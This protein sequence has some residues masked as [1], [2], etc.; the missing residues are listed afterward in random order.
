MDV[1][2]K[3]AQVKQ[4]FAAVDNPP[5]LSL[6]ELQPA[7]DED[8]TDSTRSF[9]KEIYEHWKTRK[10]GTNNRPLIPS[11]KVGLLTYIYQVLLTHCTV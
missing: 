7:I 2:E 5:V 3:T 10:L 9:V 8:L 6:A 1:L 4:P 11:L